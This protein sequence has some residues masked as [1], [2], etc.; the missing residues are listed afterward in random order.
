MERLLKLQRE[1]SIASPIPTE[2][3]SPLPP[4]P[5]DRPAISEP[6]KKIIPLPDT[7]IVSPIE[8][9]ESGSESI[10][11]INEPDTDAIASID[12]TVESVEPISS[13]ELVTSAIETVGMT[14]MAAVDY[15]ETK[16]VKVSYDS[17]NR[18]INKE[19]TIPDTRLGKKVQKYLTLINQL[20]YPNP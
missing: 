20:Y 19:K 11:S 10:S 15:L 7:L 17:L 18:W 2:E 13:I 4:S 12:G 6:E 8:T 16:K 3:P 1:A 14:A 9:V 5:P